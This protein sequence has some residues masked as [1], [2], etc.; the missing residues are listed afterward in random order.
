M[1]RERGLTRLLSGQQHGQTRRP[2]KG[3]GTVRE[4]VSKG[5]DTGNSGR[6]RTEDAPGR[7]GSQLGSPLVIP[8]WAGIECE[9]LRVRSRT[10]EKEPGGDSMALDDTSYRDLSGLPRRRKW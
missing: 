4:G 7:G 9:K 6:M 10:T 2:G 3:K 1:W 8:K 5:G